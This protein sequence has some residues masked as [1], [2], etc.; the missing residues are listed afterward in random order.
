MLTSI[1]DLHIILLYTHL[2]YIKPAGLMYLYK[3]LTT[4]CKYF[5]LQGINIS[6]TKILH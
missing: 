6:P 4:I 3:T 2:K 5:K 1:I